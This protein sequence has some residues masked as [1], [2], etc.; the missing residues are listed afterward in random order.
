MLNLRALASNPT[1]KPEPK[2]GPSPWDHVLDLIVAER[3][4]SALS[5]RQSTKLA[6]EAAYRKGYSAGRTEADTFRELPYR[7]DMGR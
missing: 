4:T 5:L 6:L 1:P 3:H 7:D 2:T